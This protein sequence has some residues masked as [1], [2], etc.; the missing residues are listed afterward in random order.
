MADKIAKLLAKLPTKQLIITQDVIRRLIKDDLT[1]LDIKSL[2]SRPGVYR[3]RVGE[4]RI[5]F[6]REPSKGIV[7]QSIA[8]RDERTYK[9]NY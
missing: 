2:Q 6:T 8:K 9:R 5:I 3:V 1:G 4:Y 7:I